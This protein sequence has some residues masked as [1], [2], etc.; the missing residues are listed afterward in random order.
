MLPSARPEEALFI[1]GRRVPQG[2]PYLDVLLQGRPRH[3]LDD[4]SLRH[5]QMERGKRA[6]L[7]APYDALDGFISLI[8]EKSTRSAGE[9]SPEG[10]DAGILGYPKLACA[11]EPVSPGRF[12]PPAPF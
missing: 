1:R 2:F 12:P 11:A 9:A 5:P 7:F 4:F 3:G 6:K 8:R 10:T